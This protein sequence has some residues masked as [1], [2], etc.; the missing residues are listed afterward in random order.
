ML[1]RRIAVGLGVLVLAGTAWGYSAEELIEQLDTKT[2]QKQLEAAWRLGDFNFPEVVGALAAKLDDAQTDV[3]VRAACATSLG[4][5]NDVST[6]PQIETLAKKE[7][8]KAL[9]RASCVKAMATMKQGEVIGE[10]AQMMKVEKSR[11]VLK[12]IEGALAEMQDKNQVAVAVTPLLTDEAA[13]PAAIR[14][15]GQVGGPGVIA[16]LATQLT[17]PKASVRLAV[18]KALGGIRN[19]DVVP[20]LIQYYPKANDAEKGQ[21]LSVLANHPHPEAL[22]L[23]VSELTNTQTFPALRRRSALTLGD[24]VARPAIPVLVKIMLNTTEQ[25]GLRL[26]CA[27]ALGKFSDRDDEA[28]AGL[29]G[30]LADKKIADTAAISLSRVT[31]RFFGTDRKKW[32]EWFQEHR[33]T[34][35]Q[36]K[37]VGH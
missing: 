19:P 18:I 14:V 35:G 28:I 32:E 7:D 26:T 25:A 8:E 11:L 29:I 6:Y 2:G 5:L 16:P 30:V 27:Q 37:R 12:A 24:L 34:R 15:L 9:V 1:F 33:R 4:K 17:S 36:Q 31:K 22:R 20:H 21:M 23:L 13:A 3:T 10:L